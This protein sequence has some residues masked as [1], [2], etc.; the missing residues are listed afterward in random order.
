MTL[1][2]FVDFCSIV[3]IVIGGHLCTYIQEWLPSPIILLR[4]F[5]KS[6]A[7]FS[8]TNAAHHLH[9]HM[10]ANRQQ[11]ELRETSEPFVISR[12]FRRG[13]CGGGGS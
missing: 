9:A 3:I 1:V 2:V 11:K 13:M 8:A 5:Y 12:I 7:N 10:I 4:R 6:N